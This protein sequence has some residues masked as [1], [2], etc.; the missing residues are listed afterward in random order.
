MTDDWSEVVTEVIID[1]YYNPWCESTT[2]EKREWHVFAL[3]L[4]KVFTAMAKGAR[5]HVEWLLQRPFPGVSQWMGEEGDNFRA[6]CHMPPI[7]DQTKRVWS[8]FAA[9]YANWTI[10]ALLEE[11]KKTEA[12]NIAKYGDA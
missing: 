9:E 3:F 12:E 6:R 8:I 1:H 5:Y 10:D 4:M 2:E 11:M 7:P